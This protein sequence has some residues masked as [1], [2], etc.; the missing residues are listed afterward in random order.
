MWNFRRTP[1]KTEQRHRQTW[2]LA[3][4]VESVSDREQSELL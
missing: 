1:Q 3:D 2:D 4:M